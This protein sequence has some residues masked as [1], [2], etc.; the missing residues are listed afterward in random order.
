MPRKTL[1][2]VRNGPTEEQ[3]ARVVSEIEEQEAE[4]LSLRMSYLA[5]AKQV[6][7]QIK[8]TYQ[9]AADAGFNK[10]GLKAKIKQRGYLRKARAVE[11]NLDEAAMAAL[12]LYTEKLGDF[13]GTPLGKAAVAQHRDALA[14]LVGSGEAE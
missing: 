2:V 13:A 11:N 12:E 3:I 14:T 9:D 5:D 10:K 8:D 1:A 6:R 7:E 4:I